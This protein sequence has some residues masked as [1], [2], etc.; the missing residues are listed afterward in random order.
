MSSAESAFRYV[1][2]VSV[3]AVLRGADF[4]MRGRCEGDFGAGVQS[5]GWFARA[6]GVWGGVEVGRQAGEGGVDGGRGDR[7]RILQLPGALLVCGAQ[8]HG[9]RRRGRGRGQPQGVHESV[10]DGPRQGRP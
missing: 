8:C 1:G 5:V 6:E 10:W 7:Q 9:Q 4:Y 3:S 2:V